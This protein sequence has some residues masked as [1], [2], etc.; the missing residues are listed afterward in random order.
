MSRIA[1][2]L[3]T[4]AISPVV[5]TD[6]QP[7]R[8]LDEDG[9]R[10]L[11]LDH[12]SGLGRRSSPFSGSDAVPQSPRA[13][14]RTQVRTFWQVPRGDA[15]AGF[16]PSLVLWP[17][18]GGPRGSAVSLCGLRI[19]AYAQ[20]GVQDEL[21]GSTVILD[22]GDLACYGLTY[23]PTRAGSTTSADQRAHRGGR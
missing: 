9:L 5:R 21:V 2:T 15:S 7:A 17:L 14:P 6:R 8:P 10:P 19:V 13:N 23:E 3:A 1:R 12:F 16:I 4:Q 22:G 20:A 11:G 18:A